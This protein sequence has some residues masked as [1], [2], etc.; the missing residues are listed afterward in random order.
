M[1]WSSTTTCCSPA[2]AGCPPER[3]NIIVDDL[4]RSTPNGIDG[5]PQRFGIPDGIP[6]E[7]AAVKQGWMCCVGSAWMHLSTGV[8]GPDRRFIVVVSS[9]QTANDVTARN[10]LTQAVATMFPGGR[11]ETE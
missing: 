3:A 1:T 6:G 2:R 8:V 11:I 5:Y 4:S 10:T 9:L 7:P